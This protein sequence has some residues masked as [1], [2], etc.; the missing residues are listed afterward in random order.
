MPRKITTEP[1]KRLTVERPESEY[2]LLE[3]Y[4]LEHQESK[5]QVI[6]S[7]IRR[8]QRGKAKP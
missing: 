6:R 3:V 1:I 8:L 4:C 2:K 5:R 7:F